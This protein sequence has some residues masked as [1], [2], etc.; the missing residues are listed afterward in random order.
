MLWG[1]F[2]ASVLEVGN[3]GCVFVCLLAVNYQLCY[4]TTVKIVEAIKEKN[5]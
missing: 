2:S 4:T 3:I 1:S 5:W